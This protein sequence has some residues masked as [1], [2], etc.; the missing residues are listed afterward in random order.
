MV[1]EGDWRVATC[2]HFGRCHLL[3]LVLDVQLVGG[4][5]VGGVSGFQCSPS[6]SDDGLCLEKCSQLLPPAVS[7]TRQPPRVQCEEPAAVQTTSWFA[8]LHFKHLLI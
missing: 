6:C 8:A 1:G 3:V 2:R 7:A 5:L 4:S